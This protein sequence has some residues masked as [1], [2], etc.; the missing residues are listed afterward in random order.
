M[1]DPDDIPSPIANPIVNPKTD[2]TTTSVRLDPRAG[3][4]FS[5]FQSRDYK[6]SAYRNSALY[7]LPKRRLKTWA[8]RLS[9]TTV[10]LGYLGAMSALGLVAYSSQGLPSGDEFYTP[11]RPVS[12]QIVDRYGRDLIARGAA[13][14]KRAK[15]SELPPHVSQAFIAIEDRRFYAHTGVDPIGLLRATQRNL[16]AGRVVQG[17]STLSQQLIK[18]VFLTSEQTFRRKIQEMMLAIWLEYKFTKDEVLESYLS[19]IYFGGGAWGLEAASQTYFGKDGKDLS[20]SE[21]AVLAG[22]LKAPS[23]YNPA[24]SPELAGGRTAVVLKA[25]NAAGYIDGSQQY[26]ALQAPVS[27]KRPATDNPANY[28]VD[29]MW[30]EMTDAL[31]GMPTQDVVVQTT[32]DRDAQL[33]AQEAVWRHLD[34]SKNASEAAVVTIDG[35][36]GVQVMIGGNSYG[37]TEFNRAVQAKR[38]PGSAYK[39]FVYLAAFQSGLTPWSEFEDAPI[40]LGDW[41]PTN[42]K[43]D[44]KGFMSLREAFI[45]SV[46][47]VAVRLGE[48][49]GRE[50]VVETAAH[51]GMERA[52]PLRSLS[53]GAQVTTPLTLTAAYQPFSNAGDSAP[54]HGIISI[55]TAAGT[56][57]YDRQAAVRTRKIDPHALGHMGRVM[58]DTVTSGTG[59]N[60]QLPGRDV[61]GKTGTTNDFRDAWFVGY[62]PD[63]VTGVWV[64]ADDY[65][66]MKKVTGGSIPARIWKDTMEVIVADMPVRYIPKSE[67]PIEAFAPFQAKENALEVLLQDMESAIRPLASTVES[68]MQ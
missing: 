52:Q 45:K 24:S 38:Q 29:W 58:V 26:T 47:T 46:N 23:R 63:R 8:K 34:P 3:K 42:F 59:R 37:E 67:K 13:E 31:G 36:G 19:R 51:L 55:S 27:I 1:S 41:E 53:L 62:V 60:A 6:R 56:P 30:T 64:G 17:G 39:A 15:L 61:G 18:N 5:R 35:T 9:V 49:I 43:D 25:M 54:V 7:R 14:M 10:G 2:L 33:A 4:P 40:T 65:A 68:N 16:Q 22:L 57:L 20:V 50:R 66:P 12:I 44:F 21:A 11:N 28:F 48:Q 32:L